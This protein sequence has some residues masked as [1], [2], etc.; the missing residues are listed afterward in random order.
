MILGSSGVAVRVLL[1]FTALVFAFG[2][3]GRDAHGQTDQA[4]AVAFMRSTGLWDRL[5][6]PIGEAVQDELARNSR[7]LTLTQIERLSKRA[8]E[9]YAPDRL[10]AVAAAVI[11]EGGEDRHLSAALAWEATPLGAVITKLGKEEIADKRASAIRMAEGIAV[12][13][14]SSETRRGLLG[15]LLKVS[16]AVDSV[17]SLAMNTIVAIQI[18]AV[19]ATSCTQVP[20]DEA[21]RKIKN[22]HRSELREALGPMTLG[23][24]A[25]VYAPLSDADMSEF[26]AFLETPA[27]QHVNDLEMK[28]YEAAFV[29][30]SLQFGRTVPGTKD[31][32]NP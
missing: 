20:S 23:F 30:A 17:V 26:I 19:C 6:G 5:G 11:V 8:K 2:V 13:A 31:A 29:D 27:G 7:G 9:S 3:S 21:I 25:A 16:N 18:G 15:R 28:A 4:T 1:W 22:R 10:R 12:L 24:V 14:R 32:A